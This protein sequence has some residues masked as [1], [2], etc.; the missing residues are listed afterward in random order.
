MRASSSP[1]SRQFS[2]CAI[3]AAARTGVVDFHVLDAVLGQD[4]HAIAFLQTQVI[5][6]GIGQ[7]PHTLIQFAVAHATII[8]YVD[9]GFPLRCQAGGFCGYQSYIHNR[10]RPF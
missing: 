6:Q 5:D 7:A 1:P 9:Q 10:V 8:G 2:G 3:N 4:R